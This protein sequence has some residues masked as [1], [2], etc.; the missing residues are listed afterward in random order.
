MPTVDGLQFDVQHDEDGKPVRVN[1][2]DGFAMISRKFEPEQDGW[3][4]NVLY[5]GDFPI[6]QMGRQMHALV[7]EINSLRRELFTTQQELARYK[8]LFFGEKT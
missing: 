4:E 6:I 2:D 1:T 3:M 5:P 8:G 7:N